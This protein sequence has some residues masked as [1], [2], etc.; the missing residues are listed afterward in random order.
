MTMNYY[1]NSP[2]AQADRAARR[3]VNVGDRVREDSESLRM[4]LGDVVS[5]EVR[6][7][8]GVV[9]SATDVVSPT[10]IPTQRIVVSWPEGREGVCWTLDDGERYWTPADL[11]VIL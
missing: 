1:L 10:G 4:R 8:V 6:E 2:E 9:T 11:V 3:R 7:T 5:R